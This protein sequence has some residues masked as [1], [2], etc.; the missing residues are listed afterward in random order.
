M[1]LVSPES[2]PT[3]LLMTRID[4]IVFEYNVS[5]KKKRQK[6]TGVVTE[7]FFIKRGT[8]PSRGLSDSVWIAEIGQRVF[9]AYKWAQRKVG[10]WVGRVAYVQKTRVSTGLVCRGYVTLG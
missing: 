5:A 10:R 3:V 6:I 2:L 7:L 1:R 4:Q 9:R 8:N